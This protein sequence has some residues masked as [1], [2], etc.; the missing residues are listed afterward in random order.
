MVARSLIW[1]HHSRNPSR[2]STITAKRRL[3]LFTEAFDTLPKGI[4]VNVLLYPMEGD[5]RAASSYW[6]LAMATRGSM[7]SLSEDWP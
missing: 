6:Q 2:G 5:P 4:P 1:P 7:L 3:K